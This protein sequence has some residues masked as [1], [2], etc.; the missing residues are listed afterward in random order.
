VKNEIQKI[1]DRNIIVD[2]THSIVL[3]FSNN[4]DNRIK[5]YDLFKNNI[6]I[7]FLELLPENDKLK[8]DYI[9]KILNRNIN[10][11]FFNS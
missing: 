9:N 1:I 11:K 3:D 10:N 6:F 2:T 7:P 8:K 5:I 4:K